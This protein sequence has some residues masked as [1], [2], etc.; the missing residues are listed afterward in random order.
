MQ[1]MLTPHITTELPVATESDPVLS[2]ASLP[3]R[4]TFFPLGF[5]VEIITNSPD[6]LAAAQQSWGLFRQQFACPP[7]TIRLGVASGADASSALPQAPV[8]RAREHLMSHIADA[9]NFVH[10][11]LN[12]GFAF[13]W[14]TPQTAASTLYLRY[15]I[16]EAA[17]LCMLAARH[18]TPL[19]AACIT[20]A[21][22]GMLLC[23]NSGAGKSSLAFAGA[24]TGWTFTC[25][26]ASY[27]PLDR[28]DRMVI[29]NCHQI[30][31]RDS[32]TLLFPELEGRSITP[33]A[34]GKPSIE[35]PTADLPGLV[36]SESAIVKSIVFLNRRKVHTPELLP[37]SRETAHSWFHQFLYANAASRTMQQAAL[38]HLLEVPIFELRYTDLNWA[39]ERLNTLAIKGI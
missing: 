33:R 35:V 3:L 20:V 21:G 36:I 23:G 27:L 11:D 32:G 17:A 13:G 28:S 18:T 37:F 29:G 6:V 1:R 2:N 38:R 8:T 9:Y 5:P 39:I 16:L 24:R 22:Q 34:A 30:R 25:D 4:V 7:L 10:C 15:F 26:D 31:L 19:H 14:I 12:T